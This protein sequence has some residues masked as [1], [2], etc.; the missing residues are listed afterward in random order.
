MSSH[1]LDAVERG[2]EEASIDDWGRGVKEPLLS[3]PVTVL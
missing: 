3:R 1:T 2:D